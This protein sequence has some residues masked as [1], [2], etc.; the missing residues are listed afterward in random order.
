MTKTFKFTSEHFGHPRNEALCRT[1]EVEV[2]ITAYEEDEGEWEIESITCPI[3]GEV[4]EVE[5]FPK[6]EQKEIEARA[7]GLCDEWTHEAYVEMQIA[8]AD[9][10]YDS[11]KE[12]GGES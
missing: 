12:D 9:A 11:W 4:F 1:F 10:L 2:S 5:G 7:Q 8:R 3:T 6:A